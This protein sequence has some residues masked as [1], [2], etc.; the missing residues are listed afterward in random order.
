MRIKKL[1]SR[2]QKKLKEELIEYEIRKIGRQLAGE[3]I[4]N[5]D[6]EW[7]DPE[8]TKKEKELLAARYEVT[9]A[10]ADERKIRR[11]KK[12]DFLFFKYWPGVYQ[13]GCKKPIDEKLALFV[14]DHYDTL[15]DNMQD[16]YEKLSQMGYTCELLLKPKA[17]DK[18]LGK[19]FVYFLYY[20]K[21]TKRYARA[22]FVFFTEYFMPLYANKP[23]K[24]THTVQLWHAS[25]AFKK[26]GYSTAD[27][28]WGMSRETM[29][30]FPIHNTY[31]DVFVS[32]PKVVEAY[33]DAFH[34]GTDI[35]RPLGTPRTDEYYAPGRV[36]RGRAAVEKLCPGINGRKIILY[37]PTFRGNSIKKSYIHSPLDYKALFDALSDRYIFVSK[38]HP[39]VRNATELDEATAAST[40]GFLYDISATASIEDALCAA[41]MV[42]SDYSSLIFDYSLLERPMIFY[43]YDLEEYEEGRSFYYPYR[44]FVP[45]PIVT[46]TAGIIAAV[47]EQD[48]SF[49]RERVARFRQ[50]F[51]S[52]CDGHATD[53]I[54]D[55]LINAD[56]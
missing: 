27:T 4:K 8:L 49:D 56:Q 2:K 22:K 44:D 46:D 20:R 6:P 53:R 55:Y 51:M 30:K 9:R 41:D 26:F 47:N 17:P 5:Y 36:E 11:Y 24:G 38:L 14:N 50:E 19:Q 33:D 42:I 29:E 1:L 54:L 23:R 45:G 25:G 13:K 43:A 39:L 37:A 34:C 10:L 28:S 3:M 52:A 18:G 32:A 16:I 40:E 12:R 15:P 31:T 35:I 7:P 48:R 21:F